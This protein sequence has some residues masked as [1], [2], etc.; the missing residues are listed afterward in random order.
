MYLNDEKDFFRKQI[1][2]LTETYDVFKYFGWNDRRTNW[3]Y[4]TETY[5]VFKSKFSRDKNPWGKFNR[6]I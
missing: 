4:L 5:D 6:N 3:S 2:D 1:N